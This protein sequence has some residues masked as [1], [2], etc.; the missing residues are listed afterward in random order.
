MWACGANGVL[1]DGSGVNGPTEVWFAMELD[2]K[3][4]PIARLGAAQ[5]VADDYF[6]FIVN[7]QFV[8]T[9]YVDDHKDPLTGQPLPFDIDFTSYLHDG[10]N[11]LEIHALDGYFPAAGTICNAGFTARPVQDARGTFCAGDRA[12]EYAFVDGVIVSVPVPMT[13]ALMGLGLLG[14]RR[15]APHLPVAVAA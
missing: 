7:G 3:P 4:R 5:I 15:R 8:L 14:L 9:G 1:C 10:Y 13:A 11:W 2:L 6:E 12:N